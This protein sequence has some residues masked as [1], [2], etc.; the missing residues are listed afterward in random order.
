MTEKEGKSRRMDVVGV[1]LVSTSKNNLSDRVN[2]NPLLRVI[3]KTQ[4]IVENLTN[5]TYFP[6]LEIF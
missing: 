1:I 4:I 5:Q 3:F 2:R 6:R